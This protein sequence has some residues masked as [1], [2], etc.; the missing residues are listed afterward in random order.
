MIAKTS[1]RTGV[2]LLC[3]TAVVTATAGLA[4]CGGDA[5]KPTPPGSPQNP[6]VGKPTQDAVQGRSNEASA[7]A[8]ATPGYQKLVQRQSSN[9]QS[10]FTPCNLVSPAQARAI[11]G[12]PIQAPIEA[13]QG[14]TCIYRTK[15]P[16]GFVTLAVQSVDFDKLKRRIQEPRRVDV[17]S[18]SAYCG[19]YGQP[20][21]YAPLSGTRVLSVAGPCAVAKQFAA[22]AMQRLRD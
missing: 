18:R 15:S 5:A 3:L 10:R 20:M 9:P 2:R 7:G 21:L 13:P 11:F 1:R 22:K 14:P 6:L 8:D 4:A 19:T 16:G 17:S 12:A